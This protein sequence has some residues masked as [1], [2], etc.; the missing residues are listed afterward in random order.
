[1]VYWPL[2]SVESGGLP[3]AGAVFRHGIFSVVIWK[4]R[5]EFA[6]YVS[7]AVAMIDAAN[8]VRCVLQELS[9]VEAGAVWVFFVGSF[10]RPETESVK[11]VPIAPLTRPTGVTW[12]LLRVAVRI[13]A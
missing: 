6:M 4:H 5:T 7:F 13:F 3:N 2:F 12:V 8:R 11:H 10:G 1:M 9:W